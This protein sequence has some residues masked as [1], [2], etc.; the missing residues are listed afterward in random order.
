MRTDSLGNSGPPA[1]VLHDS[2]DLLSGQRAIGV[3]PALEYRIVVAGSAAKRLQVRPELRGQE[4]NSRFRSLAVVAHLP[5]A[6]PCFQV[7]P[8]QSGAVFSM[9]R[10]DKLVASCNRFDP[11]D[12][13]PEG[14]LS[15]RA[16]GQDPGEPVGRRRNRSRAPGDEF[17]SAAGANDGPK[18]VRGR[19]GRET[20]LVLRVTG[21]GEQARAVNALAMRVFG[22]E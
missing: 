6:A 14:L 7:S 1:S 16:A 19:T 15:R 17:A 4:H 18:R 11:V 9:P 2:K 10:A 8:L 20:I 3:F 13:G 5:A 21:I 12:R 22:C